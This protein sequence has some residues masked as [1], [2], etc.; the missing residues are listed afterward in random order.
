MNENPKTGSCE[1]C[2]D[3]GWVC[4]GYGWPTKKSRPQTEQGSLNTPASDSRASKPG[5]RNIGLGSYDM[6]PADRNITTWNSNHIQFVNRGG[7]GSSAYSHYVPV[8]GVEDGSSWF[9]TSLIMDE[10]SSQILSS[11]GVDYEQDLP[12]TLYVNGTGIGMNINS[13]FDS[14]KSPTTSSLYTEQ[15]GSYQIGQGQNQAP[16]RRQRRRHDHR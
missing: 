9:D 4:E 8:N 5:Y 12:G 11:F 3:R 7:S 10:R 2:K 13:S 1:R 14:S 16:V 6:Q 15:D